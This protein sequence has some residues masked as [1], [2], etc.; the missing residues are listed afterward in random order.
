MAIARDVC[1]NAN[2][3]SAGDPRACLAGRFRCARSCCFQRI[4]IGAVAN[5]SALSR[6]CSLLFTNFFRGQFEERSRL[7]LIT[8][9]ERSM[10]MFHP[11]ALWS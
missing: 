2:Q 1:F 4:P 10:E 6:S 8:V 11:R 9:C 5:W 3:Y 7:P